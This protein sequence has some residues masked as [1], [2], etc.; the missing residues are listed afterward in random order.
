MVYDTDYTGEC[1]ILDDVP[2]Q[3]VSAVVITK[4]VGDDEDDNEDGA[5]NSDHL[6]VHGIYEANKKA[7]DYLKDHPKKV[8]EYI[9]SHKS[10]VLFDIDDVKNFRVGK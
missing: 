8:K 4:V 6:E 10:E 7:A 2:V 9:D 5:W 3:F 1:W